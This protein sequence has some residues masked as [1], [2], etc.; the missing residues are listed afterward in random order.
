MCSALWQFLFTPGNKLHFSSSIFKAMPFKLQYLITSIISGQKDTNPSN[1]LSV[2]NNTSK[3]TRN[4][5][6]ST[7][8]NTTEIK[9]FAAKIVMDNKS[10]KFRL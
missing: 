10:K 6:Y 9:Q 7:A 8:R 1:C 5:H 4:I 3:M 2:K